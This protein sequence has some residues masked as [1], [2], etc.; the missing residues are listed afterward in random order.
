MLKKT[1]QDT[2]EYLPEYPNR[3]ANHAKLVEESMKLFAES[4]IW[5]QQF[6]KTK[7]KAKMFMLD[8]MIQSKDPTQ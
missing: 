2:S 8:K 7:A 5:Q 4:E 3:P 6:V 1:L